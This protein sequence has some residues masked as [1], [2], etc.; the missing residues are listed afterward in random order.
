MRLNYY[1]RDLVAV[2]DNKSQN[3]DEF[4]N[5]SILC[6]ISVHPSVITSSFRMPIR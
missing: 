2:Y 5:K 1:P 4:N 6:N 3:V